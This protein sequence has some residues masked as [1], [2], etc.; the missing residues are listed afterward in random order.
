MARHI[1]PPGLSQSQHATSIEQLPEAFSFWLPGHK[2]DQFFE[3]NH[4]YICKSSTETYRLFGSYLLSHDQLFRGWPELWLHHDGTIPMQTWFITCLWKDFPKLIAGQS[5]C[6]G[7][8]TALAECGTAPM[9]IQTTGRWT[10]DTFNHYVHK[11]PFLLC[12][13]HSSALNSWFSIFYMV[14]LPI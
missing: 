3:G 14:Y 10:F 5:M 12:A 2:V 9:L 6:A 1:S 7:G 13:P 8:A 4:L 11:N